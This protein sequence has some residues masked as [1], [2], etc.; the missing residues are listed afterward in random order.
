[1]R[2][3]KNRE[4][5]LYKTNYVKNK[6]KIK[7]LKK[8]TIIFFRK[9]TDLRISKSLLW[10]TRGTKVTIPQKQHSLSRALPKGFKKG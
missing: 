10:K 1:M 9:I 2:R 5:Y 6:K 7:K 4:S 8:K 3:E